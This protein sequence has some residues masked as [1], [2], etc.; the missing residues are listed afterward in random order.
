MKAHYRTA[1]GRITF[2]LD[3]STPK[4]IFKAIAEVHDVFEADTAECG[5][6]HKN[7]IIFRVRVNEDNEFYELYCQSCTAALSFGQRKAG[8]RLYAKRKDSAGKLLPDGGWAVYQ[9]ANAA[10]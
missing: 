2:E 4:E 8:G 5:C 7:R 1:S 10:S 9:R 3:G 6:C